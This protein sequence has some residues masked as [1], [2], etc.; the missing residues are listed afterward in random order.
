[1]GFWP[2][3]EL[4]TLPSG[5]LH[6]EAHNMVAGFIKLKRRESEEEGAM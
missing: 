1:M 4:S 2:E 6:R 5:P 3:A